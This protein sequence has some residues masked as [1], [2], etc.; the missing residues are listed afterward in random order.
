MDRSRSY[1]PQA[2]TTSPLPGSSSIPEPGDDAPPCML[3]VILSVGQYRP[4]SDYH[5][6][7]APTDP[8]RLPNPLSSRRGGTRMNQDEI[9]LYLWRNSTLRDVVRL[10][11]AAAHLGHHPIYT[12]RHSSLI[13]A[14]PFARHGIRRVY[15]DSRRDEFIGREIAGGIT[16]V[17]PAEYQSA[18]LGSTGS[19]VGADG[20][21]GD[22][23]HPLLDEEK[24]DLARLKAANGQGDG[25]SAEQN[26]RPGG[27]GSGGSSSAR[28]GTEAGWTLRKC[29]LR[30]GDVVECVILFPDAQDQAADRPAGLRGPGGPIPPTQRA[31]QFAAGPIRASTYAPGLGRHQDSARHH[32]YGRPSGSYRP[33]GG[34][35]G[36]SRSSGG[37]GFAS[38]GPEPRRGS[39]GGGGSGW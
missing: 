35:R 36:G 11:H 28:S 30:D 24:E 6:N 20:E 8:A 1:S 14:S 22:E 37:P 13:A 15:F 25:G 34:F 17:S 21:D 38:R 29:Q 10:A 2:R 31:S 3:R 5:F 39:G 4:L 9:K 12:A 27:G 23:L 7:P 26:G 18:L 19:G 33:S 16:R 32:P